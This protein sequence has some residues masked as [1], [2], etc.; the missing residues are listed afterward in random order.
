MS[1]RGE[2]KPQAFPRTNSRQRGPQAAGPRAPAGVDP[3][4]LHLWPSGH[5]SSLAMAVGN[6]CLIKLTA[7]GMKLANRRTLLDVH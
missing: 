4:P 1:A 2:S 3:Y 7:K 6:P 5:T